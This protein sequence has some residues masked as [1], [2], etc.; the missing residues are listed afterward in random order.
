MGPGGTEGLGISTVMNQTD[1]H[2]STSRRLA[3]VDGLRAAAALWVVFFHI[4]SFSQAKFAHVPGLDLFLRSGSTGVSLFLVLSG[5]CLYIP[6]A[7][8]RTDRFRAGRFFLRRCRRLMPA[9]YVSL[10][11]A[12]AITV[13]G[14]AWLGFE[15][16]SWPQL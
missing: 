6:F 2:V 15:H 5:F 16:F 1:S 8:G 12:V 11:L 4:R 3:G 9:Y 7:G 14:G 13:L 10:V